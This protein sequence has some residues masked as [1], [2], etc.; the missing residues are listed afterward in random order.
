MLSFFLYFFFARFDLFRRPEY[1]LHA[2]IR[3]RAKLMDGKS[4]ISKDDDGD[5]GKKKLTFLRLFS[6]G[7]SAYPYYYR[8]PLS[9][10]VIYYFQYFRFIRFGNK[11][12]EN[13]R[14]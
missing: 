3:R 7:N 10:W 9:Q 6:S 4:W 14:K 1:I 12:L 2:K 13:E 5:V 8:R 11:K